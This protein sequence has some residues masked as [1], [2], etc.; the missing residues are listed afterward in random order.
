VAWEPLGSDEF[1]LAK[2]S[3]IARAWITSPAVVVA[4]VARRHDTKRP[5]G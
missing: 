2:M 4:K 1:L 3:Q 5:D